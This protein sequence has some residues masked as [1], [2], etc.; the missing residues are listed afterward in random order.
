MGNSDTIGII[1]GAEPGA[2]GIMDISVEAAVYLDMVF[3]V[4]AGLAL[5]ILVCIGLHCIARR[6][7]IRNSWLAW[8]PV[9]N[10]W[11]LGSISDQYQYL[12]KGRIRTRR[13]VLPTLAVLTVLVYLAA[14]YCVFLS[15]DKGYLNSAAFAVPMLLAFIFV[16]LL[17]AGIITVIVYQYMCFYDLFRSCDPDNR[18]L[19]LVLSILYP[20]GLPFIVFAIRKRDGGMPPR[21]QPAPIAEEPAEETEESAEETKETNKEREG[22]SEY[23]Q[24][25]PVADA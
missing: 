11:V 10:L 15:T 2:A 19:F 1:G 17:L 21:K 16:A 12:V 22:E 6:R 4:L 18:K 13:G 7:W 25:K 20:V 9:A 3:S 8:V 5:Y 14:A 23:G 24:E